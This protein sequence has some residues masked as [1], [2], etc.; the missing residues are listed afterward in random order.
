[1]LSR[2]S[3]RAGAV[4]WVDGRAEAARLGWVFGGGR[5]GGRLGAGDLRLLALAAMTGGVMVHFG[6]RDLVGLGAVGV[7]MVLAFAACFAPRGR[8]P[9]PVAWAVAGVG[10]ALAGLYD[11]VWAVTYWELLVVAVGAVTAAVVLPAGRMRRL[12]AVSAVLAG[13]AAVVTSITFGGGDVDVY[14]I[15]QRGPMLL[16]HGVNPYTHVLSA[17]GFDFSYGPTVLLLS[18][19]ARLLGDSRWMDL[20]AVL[21]AGVLLIR[22]ARARGWDPDE[23]MRLAV[24]CAVMPLSA[25]LVHD[26]FVD[27]YL[28]LGLVL[29]VWLRERHTLWAAACLGA[30]L[31]TA[32]PTLLVALIP[33]ALWLPRARREVRLAALF[34]AAIIAPFAIATGPATL[35][36]AVIGS[37]LALPPRG[38]TM[39]LDAIVAALGHPFLPSWT[40]PALTA[41]VGIP[42]LAR[43]PISWS[44]I[45]GT[46]AVLTAAGAFFAKWAPINYWM[47]PAALLLLAVV[48][49]APTRDAVAEPTRLPWSRAGRGSI[50]G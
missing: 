35:Y 38:D 19:P 39:S 33:A 3:A 15:V 17:T 29:W 1:L 9:S 24:L 20:L 50:A 6:E 18:I 8:R 28:V 40:W 32:K 45:C 37:E 26:A 5:T 48:L 22:V 49:D 36:H 16:M 10:C 30:A 2:L 42:L 34:A 47:L 46:A 13:I 27:V 23:R 43:R 25:A 14:D 44:D 31:A 21:A 11:H 41:A 7:G 12:A 4:R